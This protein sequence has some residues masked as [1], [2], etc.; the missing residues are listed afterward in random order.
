[1]SRL[2]KKCKQ[3]SLGSITVGKSLIAMSIAAI[4]CAC[5]QQAIVQRS[6]MSLAYGWI[7]VALLAATIGT[8]KWGT[9]GFY[10]GYVI[11]FASV[12]VLLLVIPPLFFMFS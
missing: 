12:P 5:I 1:M 10:V 11:G 4:A 3:S 9:T 2:A 8:V 6:A 7:S